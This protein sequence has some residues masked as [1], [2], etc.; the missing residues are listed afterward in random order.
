MLKKW[1]KVKDSNEFARKL[2]IQHFEAAIE[3]IHKLSVCGFDEECNKQLDKIL[4]MKY[5]TEDQQ[6]S[7]ADCFYKLKNYNKCLEIITNIE[8]S[9][10][11]DE[12][13]A[14]LKKSSLGLLNL[15]GLALK[16]LGRFEDARKVWEEC[17]E[18]NPTYKFAMNNLGNL[19]MRQGD[20]DKAID[21]YFQSK[22][23]KH[24]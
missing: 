2:R 7:V 4:E 8:E 16:G 18:L 9:I 6:L 23:C 19:S 3:N 14:K 12:R 20:Y 11:K 10:K 17:L 21:Y 5:L 13:F 22:E 15:K 1:N 24:L